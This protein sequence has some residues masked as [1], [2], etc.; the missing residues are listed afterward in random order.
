MNTTT[1]TEALRALNTEAYTWKFGLY[2]TYKGRDGTELEW[3][4]CNMKGIAGQVDNL[5]EYLLKKPE[6]EKPVAEYSPFLSD[7]ENIGALEQTNVIIRDQIRDII[8]GFQSGLYHSPEDFVSGALSKTFGYAF[9]GEQRDDAGNVQEQALFMRRGNPFLTAQS[10]RLLIGEGSEIVACEKPVLKFTQSVD[11]L[12]IGGACYILS[13]SIEKDL[14]L[15]SRNIAIAQK[16]MGLI[17]E[18]EI[19]NNYDKLEACV[20][21]AK[22]ARKFLNFDKAVLEHIE[23]LPVVEREEFL[24]T[25]GVTVDFNGRMDTS[26][27][28]QCELIVDLLCCRSCLDPLGRLSVGS[29]IAPRE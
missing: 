5:R 14:S 7:K 13:S 23:R 18:A 1:L 17:A 27:E 6:A 15:E 19:V 28:E 20:M 22:N 29:N 24:S 9:Y 10:A 26:D 25:Y 3:N 8:L 21:K 4:L 12:L 16:R 11:F 2:S